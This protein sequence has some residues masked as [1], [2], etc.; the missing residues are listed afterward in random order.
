MRDGEATRRRRCRRLPLS[1][2][3]QRRCVCCPC[4]ELHMAF[5][6]IGLLLTS[7]EIFDARTGWL[8]EGTRAADGS[9][10]EQHTLHCSCPTARTFWISGSLN[11]TL[12]TYKAQYPLR[13][14]SI[15]LLLQPCS[16]E[17]RNQELSAPPAP[18]RLQATWQL[19]Q[20]RHALQPLSRHGLC[21]HHLPAALPAPPCGSGGGGRRWQETALRR[22]RARRRQRQ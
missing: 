13:Q 12:C 21:S 20:A 3:C 14:L 7:G 6:L 8:L 18:R 9:R 4:R 10:P 1:T 19:P 2:D 17:Q 11:R 5:V 16:P 22:R 15:S